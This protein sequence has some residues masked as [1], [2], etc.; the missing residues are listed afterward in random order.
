[1]WRQSGCSSRSKSCRAAVVCRGPLYL[2]QA[3]FKCVRQIWVRLG[4]KCPEC[5]KEIPDGSLFCENC[6][7]EIKIVPEYET[8][9]EEQISS[10]MESVTRVF[11]EEDR[12]I[13]SVQRQPGEDP[14]AG[15][16]GDDFGSGDE[17]ENS[18]SHAKEKE[19]YEAARAEAA[20]RR[21]AG[22][23]ARRRKVTLM[24]VF[25]VGAVSAAILLILL[26]IFVFSRPVQNV[27]YYV[28]VAYQYSVEERY[29]EAAAAIEAALALAGEEDAEE[30]DTASLLLLAADYYQ[31]D[32]RT[33]EALE[34]GYAVLEM[35]DLTE[36][37]EISAYSLLISVYASLEEYPSIAELLS[38]CTNESVCTSY[39]QYML[40]EP[41]FTAEEGDYSDQLTIEISCDGDGTVFYTM[42]GSEPTTS[43]N[44]YKGPIELDVGSYTISAIYV[45]RVGVQSETVTAVYNIVSSV[46]EAPVITPNSGTYAK[47]M[48]ITASYA[49]GEDDPDLQEESDEASASEEDFGDDE[50][51][52]SEEENSEGTVSR[53][54]G[55]I[56]YTTDGTV[57]TLESNVYTGPI[58]IPEGTT[59]Y[60]FA[61]ITEDG[62][63]SEV[64]ER[65][66]TYRISTTLSSEDGVNYILVA[67][68]LRGEVVDTIGTVPGG[69][70]RFSF[71]YLGIEQI[72]GSG[73]YL[74]YSESLV[75]DEGN[76][77]VT[78]RVYAVNAANGTV[79]L[80]ADGVLTPI[81]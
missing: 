70:A 1:M 12:A 69:T 78:G 79:N 77:A 44:I 5:G 68:I 52:D 41:E 13:S 50:Q 49:S 3:F 7:A 40:Y 6:A 29:D 72:S 28:G 66:Y 38:E 15:G 43:S 57:P 76:S 31:A 65:E 27:S 67:L 71:E 19:A 81:G 36:D 73:N 75:D 39:H 62:V 20:A 37:D 58:S 4:M 9:L 11:A 42:D 60:R 59:V 47:Q 30:T 64:V 51:E 32:G 10:G 80:Y 18:E 14:A 22:Y 48:Q 45:N 74:I 63:S 53:A 25:L 54:T 2:R 26:Y 33:D 16:E 23:E 55:Y 17:T 34:A 61:V 35:D 21:Q 56:Y 46:P 24:V 8:R